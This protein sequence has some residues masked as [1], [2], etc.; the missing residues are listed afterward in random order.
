MTLAARVQVTV[1]RLDVDVELRVAPGEVVAL[2]GPN[3]AGKTT[4]LRALAGLVPLARGRIVLRDRVLDDP[5][6][7]AFV[8]PAARGV[9]MVFQDQRLFPHLTA[10]ANVAFPLRARGRPR[11]EALALLAAVGL[12]RHADALPAQLSGGQAQKVAL[13][14]ALAGGPALLLLDEPLAGLDGDARTDMHGLLARQLAHVG[15][16]CVIVTHDPEDVRALATRTVALRA[17]RVAAGE[18]PPPA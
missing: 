8:P 13:A 7:G 15:V 18:A 6:T 14:R 5:A 17:G 12:D 10:E 3:G 11:S 4:T 1:G 2:V 9:G 16:P